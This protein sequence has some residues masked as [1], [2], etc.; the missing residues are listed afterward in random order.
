MFHSALKFAHIARAVQN[1][2]ERAALLLACSWPCCEHA[3]Y[4]RFRLQELTALIQYIKYNKRSVLPMQ[5]IPD[6]VT[7]ASKLMDTL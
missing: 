7:I 4:V 5:W 2:T 1:T 3:P 6:R